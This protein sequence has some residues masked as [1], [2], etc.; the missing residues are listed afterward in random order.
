LCHVLCDFRLLLH[1]DVHQP[2]GVGTGLIGSLGYWLEQ[3]EVRRGNQPQYYYLT[4]ILPMYE[5]LP[6]I[7]SMLAM[8]A[9]LT[10]FWRF[11]VASVKAEADAHRDAGIETLE[12]VQATRQR[13]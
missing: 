4:V 1:D 9:G 12:A 2:D 3:Q 8:G 5:Y 10:W 7:G 11:R 6:A 13:G